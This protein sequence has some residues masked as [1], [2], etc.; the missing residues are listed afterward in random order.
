M[1]RIGSDEVCIKISITGYEFPDM[2][3]NEYDSNWLE[4]T[5]DIASKMI[6][7]TPAKR[8]FVRAEELLQL[9]DYLNKCMNGELRDHVFEF[10]DGTLDVK[11]I[12]NGGD[13]KIAVD[14]FGELTPG[15]SNSGS[16]GFTV[17]AGCKDIEKTM[18]GLRQAYKKFPCKM[19]A[20]KSFKPIKKFLID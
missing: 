6:T 7:E 16:F 9:N 18:S 19:K 5:L 3:N 10:L 17:D 20:N 15:V 1:I 8:G 4:F 11:C 2:E 14:L 13:Y 12:K